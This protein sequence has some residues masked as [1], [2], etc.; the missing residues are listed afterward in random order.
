MIQEKIQKV[1]SKGDCIHFKK[2]LHFLGG[3][4]GIRE[5]TIELKLLI[6]ETQSHPLQAV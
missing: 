5:L 3:R 1:E 6:N 4:T 2:K